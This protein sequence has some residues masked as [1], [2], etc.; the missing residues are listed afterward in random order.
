M[1]QPW[2]VPD[3]E[4]EPEL[5]W[6]VEGDEQYAVEAAHDEWDV[7]DSNVTWPLVPPRRGFRPARCEQDMINLP[8]LYQEMS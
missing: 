5:W 3:D 4:E 2:W 6:F 7:P 8:H 1:G